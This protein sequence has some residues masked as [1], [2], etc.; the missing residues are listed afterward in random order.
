MRV[1]DRVDSATAEKREFQLGVLSLVVIAVLGA[2]MALLMYP[3]VTEHPV[4]FTERTTKILFFGFC[5]LCLLLFG[6]LLNRQIVVRRLRREVTAA[7]TRYSELHVQASQDLMKTLSGMSRFQDQLMMEHKR[8]VNCGKPLS[9]AVI[10]LKPAAGLTDPDDVTATL[11][12]AVMAIT[13]KLKPDD[14]LYNFLGGAFGVILHGM[15]IQDAHLVA[16]RLSDGLSDA[17]GAVNRFT[18]DVKI[19]NYPQHAG[20]AYELEKAVTA[21]LPDDSAD[22]LDP[23]DSHVSAGQSK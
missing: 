13:R 23:E 20:S 9:V 8:S 17:A 1:F 4:Y 16:A 11:G 2:G 7:R 21:L 6:Y 19:V 18:F 22:A 5:G 15:N 3:N 14:S 10:R 12:D